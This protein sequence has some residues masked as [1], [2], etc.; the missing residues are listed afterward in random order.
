M[1][2]WGRYQRS[3]ISAFRLILALG[4]FSLSCK[5]EINPIPICE[6][7]GA[8]VVSPFFGQRVSVTGIVTADLEDQRPG[9]FYLQDDSCLD[10]HHGRS[11]GVF[12][13]EE[14][15]YDLVSRGDE[16]F[17]RGLVLEYNQETI[18]SLERDSLEILSINNPLP[19]E[20]E[21][22]IVWE[23]TSPTGDYEQWEGMLVHFPKAEVVLG[24]GTGGETWVLPGI[25]GETRK[26]SQIQESFFPLKIFCSSPSQRIR[27]IKVGD[28]LENLAGIIRQDGAD[29]VLFLLDPAQILIYPSP[30]QTLVMSEGYLDGNG[31]VSSDIMDPT[32]PWTDIP[33]STPTYYPIELLLVEIFPNPSGDEPEGEWIEIYNPNSSGFPLTGIKVGDDADQSGKEGL[34]SFPPGYTIEAGEVLVIANHGK[35]F[36]KVYG[37]YPDFE[38]NGSHPDIPDMLPYPK[39]GSSSIQLSNS[40][41]EVVLLD[42]WNGVLDGISYGSSSFEDFGPRVPVPAEG[43]S[44]ERYPPERDRDKPGDW[45]ERE[46]VSPGKLDRS[47]STP[48]PTSTSSP[49][50]TPTPLPEPTY[51]FTPVIPTPT[52][53]QVRLLITEVMFN[54][55]GIEPEGEWFEVYNPTDR[56]Y[57]LNGVKMGDAAFRGDS[58]GMY[59]FPT[60]EQILPGELVLIANHAVVFNDSYGFN[61]DY[62]LSDSDPE[63]LDLIPYPGWATGSVR[64]GNGGDELVLLNGWDDIVDIVAYGNSDCDLFQPPAPAGSEGASLARCPQDAD[65]D[66][67]LDWVNTDDPSPGYGNT[68]APT[69]TLSPTM[70]MTSTPSSTLSSEPTGTSTGILE[71]SQTA[72]LS[73]T[74]SFS[75]TPSHTS[76]ITPDPSCTPSP[77][78]TITPSKTNSPSATL[79]QTPT[80]VTKTPTP[81]DVNHPAIILNEIHADPH[82][83]LGDANGDGK[84]DSDDDEFLEIVNIGEEPFDLSGWEI[85]DAVRIR[86]IFPQNTILPVMGA[87][88]VFGGGE[89]EGEFGGNLVL[90]SGTLGLNNSGDT[91]NLR[92][93]QGRLQIRYDFGVEASQDQSLTRDPDLVGDS[94]FV[95][96]SKA[97]LSGGTLYSPGTRMDGEPFG[98]M[99]IEEPLIE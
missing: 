79:P 95:L 19:E 75:V 80:L 56:S 76:T 74:M 67:L 34:M 64:L 41:D 33:E 63:V 27:T 7:Q 32:S 70:T 57:P 44:L 22:G 65:T 52:P 20:D 85:S 84:I 58:E 42:P 36:R 9:G 16:V 3:V 13:L 61:P 39:S 73:P 66:S 94:P 60:G 54:P 82:P 69:Y 37:F 28:I 87:V 12:I 78:P 90:T 24:E 5:K 98:A 29:Y 83:L 47:P 77:Q 14:R 50:K 8:G 86:F 17:L 38:M 43:N 2:N 71:K 4:S 26:A 45:R 99:K 10:D 11:S 25:R 72:T 62:E 51:T 55:M 96:H 46:S 93:D 89:P 15:D 53:V 1:K 92:D 21:K 49:Q 59:L 40:G 23:G 18:L 91:I 30:S 81:E 88:V 6:I 97:S 35:T 48:Q 31:E 68:C